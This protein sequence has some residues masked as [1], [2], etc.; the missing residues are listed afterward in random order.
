MTPWLN[1][2]SANTPAQKPARR[3]PRQAGTASAA[4][5]RQPLRATAA[6]AL[7]YGA[8]LNPLL[9]LLEMT[10]PML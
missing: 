8:L 9:T 10:S 7:A 2:N 6:R 3:P 4:Q 1:Q 5:V